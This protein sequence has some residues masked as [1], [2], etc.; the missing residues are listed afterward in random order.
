M[1]DSD[2][3]RVRGLTVR[4]KPEDTFGDEDRNPGRGSNVYSHADERTCLRQSIVPMSEPL[5]P[6]LARPF[7]RDGVSR[8]ALSRSQIG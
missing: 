7:R 3:D 1:I 5:D 4:P 2:K 6:P 8:A